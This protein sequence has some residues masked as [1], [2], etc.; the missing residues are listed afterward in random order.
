MTRSLLTAWIAGL[1][2]G[3]LAVL[4]SPAHAQNV[5]N[6]QALYTNNCAMCHGTGATNATDKN[7]GKVGNVGTANT[8]A[9]ITKL[10]NACKNT[11]GCGNVVTATDIADVVAYIQSK[12]GV[13]PAPT[14]APAV[15]L[16]G[17][18]L[19]FGNVT[20]GTTS[21]AA[22]LTVSNTGTADLMISAITPGGSNPGDFAVGGT[23]A[24][25]A[26]AAGKSCTVSA[27][28]TP[29][30]AGARSATF[31]LTSNAPNSPHVLNLSGMGVAAGT[32]A[33]NVAPMMLAFG[34]VTVGSAAPTQNVTI[35][36]T[37]TLALSVGAITLSGAQAADFSASGCA[38]S[39]VAAGKSCT[40]TVGYKPAAAGPGAATLQVVYGATGSPASV[41]LSGTGVAPA[42]GTSMAIASVSPATLD[43]GT[44]K[45]GT[46]SAAKSV[47]VTNTGT[48][49]LTFKSFA[50]SGGNATDFSNPSGSCTTTT[51][52]DVGKSCGFDVVFTPAASGKRMTT[53]TFLSNAADATVALSGSGM[54]DTN[55]LIELTQD[56]LVIDKIKVKKDGSKTKIK[57]RNTST[58]P[59]TVKGI[60]FKVG[61]DYQIDDECTGKTLQPGKTC[62]I[63]IE[64]HPKS[65]SDGSSDDKSDSNSDDAITA[66]TADGSAVTMPVTL[67]KAA[68]PTATAPALSVT[69]ATGA[70]PAAAG[71]CTLGNGKQFDL[72]TLLLLLA[73]AGV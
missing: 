20:V 68:T 21:A 18:S 66:T 14:T 26:L 5:A 59:I 42:P 53:L 35:N 58:Q 54:T 40:V 72:S 31:T 24:V 10:T 38:N 4:L 52:L 69:P 37:G 12:N 9:N 46:A 49:A 36:N 27:T 22:A 13:S 56:G 65:S 55:G 25:G 63:E 64:Y 32:T 41:A 48:A 30:A 33:G 6:G 1:L 47:T 15:S 67:D 8:A 50:F 70:T 34:N 2:L 3:V 11:M 62:Q 29:A 16:S 23:C 44:L 71:G 51:T 43:F 73:A 19:A 57:L 61:A 28:F 60:V 39:S 7:F 45:V 17:S